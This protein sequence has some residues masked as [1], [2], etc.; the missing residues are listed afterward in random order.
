VTTAPIRTEL[1]LGDLQG[2]I[3]SAY[4]KMGFP[5][6]RYL[7]FH[8]DR[9][10][11]G[12]AF[13][14]ALRPKV[15]TALRW[16]S[17]KGISTGAVEVPRPDCTLNLAFTFWGLYALGVPTRTLRGMPDEFVDGM[18]LRAPMLGDDIL[19]NTPANWDPVWQPEREKPHILVML[20]AKV[21]A[22]GHALPA[23]DAMTAMVLKAAAATDGAVRL[24]EG[25][26]GPDPR[27]QELS[28]IFA[29]APDGTRRALPTEHFGFVDAIGDPV[30]EGQYPG[31]EEDL[32]AVGQGAMDGEGQWRPLAT[33]E[34]ILGWPDE[35]QEVAGAAMPLDFSRN[36]SFFAYRKLHQHVER[37]DQWVAERAKGLAATWE[38]ADLAEAEALLK[39]KMC[40]RWPDGVPLLL[41]PTEAD[42][43]AFNARL[44]P[45][46]PEW[47][48][49]ITHFDYCD[50]VDGAKCPVTS[51]MRRANTRDMLDPLWDQPK[52]ARMGSALNNRR[53]ILRRGLP[54]GDRAAPDHDHGIVLL[55]HCANLFRQFEF[56][57]Q[58]WMNYGL[59][60]NAGNDSCPVVGAH[61]PGAR[62]VIAAPDASKPPFIASGL[63]QFV[64][65]RGGDYF[66]APSMTALRMI[67]QGVVD[68]T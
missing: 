42:R 33:G 26:A 54:Y 56:V 49:A 30:F 36:G 11:A 38:I 61:S 29:D 35:A 57:Q 58:Q 21:D 18:A 8:V 59:D 10:A 22:A 51:H 44:K 13:V 20:N 7:L 40:G 31:R 60:F 28:A 4:G 25:H 24:L 9:S 23:L 65:T 6:A 50:D 1:E 66:F 3:L 39:A 15:T 48:A 37:W 12:R 5:K 41:A 68:P 32:R 19:D 16:P 27:W 45:G 53:R 34:F 64:S 43:Q 67:G 2:G 62:F 52:K 14:E 63:P 47:L 55:A 17:S 46:S